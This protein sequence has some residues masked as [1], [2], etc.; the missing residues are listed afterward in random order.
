MLRLSIKFDEKHRVKLQNWQK[1]FFYPFPNP[2]FLKKIDMGLKK[3][4]F[5]APGPQ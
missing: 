4:F 2:F 3:C 5:I 1:N